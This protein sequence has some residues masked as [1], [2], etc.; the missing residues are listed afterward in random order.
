MII[1]HQSIKIENILN[2]PK[3]DELKFEVTDIDLNI[4]LAN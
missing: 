3:S 2:Q 4:G 1:G